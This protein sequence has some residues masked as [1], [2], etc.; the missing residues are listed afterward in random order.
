MKKVLVVLVLGMTMFSC[1]KDDSINESTTLLDYAID[2]GIWDVEGADFLVQF[3]SQYEAVMIFPQGDCY[4]E[5]YDTIKMDKLIE[6]TYYIALWER[7]NPFNGTI[8]LIEWSRNGDNTINT[9][10]KEEGGEWSSDAY[11]NFFRSSVP[12]C[13]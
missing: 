7:S 9:R 2:K 10:Y 1:S 5:Y 8:E 4:I 11:L 3:L 6:S 13:N 12:I